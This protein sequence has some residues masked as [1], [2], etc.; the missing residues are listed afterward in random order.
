MCN[1]MKFNHDQKRNQRNHNVIR[2]EFVCESLTPLCDTSSVMKRV[3]P[4]K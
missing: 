4:V 1:Y 3:K 2:L